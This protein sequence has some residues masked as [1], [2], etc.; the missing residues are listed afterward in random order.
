MEERK[1]LNPGLHVYAH[2]AQI[3]EHVHTCAKGR[4]N[5]DRDH[6][7]P[8][9]GISISASWG[10][11]LKLSTPAESSEL[12]FTAGVQVADRLYDMSRFLY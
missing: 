11:G 2:T 4:G 7:V 5:E 9:L 10:S 6:F 12:S 8:V 1:D 3:H